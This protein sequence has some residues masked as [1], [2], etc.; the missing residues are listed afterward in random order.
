MR[1]LKALVMATAIMMMSQAAMAAE[2]GT[3]T[4]LGTSLECDNSPL[5]TSWFVGKDVE[6]NTVFSCAVVSGVWQLVGWVDYNS[7]TVLYVEGD[8][9]AETISIVRDEDTDSL[10]QSSGSLYATGFPSGWF[11]SGIFVHGYEGDDN[12]R[13]SY[14]GESLYGDGDDDTVIGNGGDDCIYGGGGTDTLSGI[15]GT[16]FMYGNDGND[17]VYGGDG[18][19]YVWGGTGNDAIYGYAGADQLHGDA[20]RDYIYG[21]DNNDKI[22]GDAD[23]DRCWGEAN[24][25][26]PPGDACECETET[27]CETNP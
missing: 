16:N 12:I 8:Y 24:D 11:S 14:R 18:V 17:T 7:E 9:I 19:D 23:S 13:G 2:W 20:G 27:T 4:D 21:G 25:S 10:C 6:S 1:L 3:C 15:T 26:N 5:Y 22:W